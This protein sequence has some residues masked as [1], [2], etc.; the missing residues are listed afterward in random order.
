MEELCIHT[1]IHSRYQVFD[2][3]GQHPFSIVFGLCRR[4]PNDIDTRPIILHTANSFLDV[5]YAIAHGLLTLH[6]HHGEDGQEVRVDLVGRLRLSESEFGTYLTV[7]SPVDRAVHWREAMAIYQYPIEPDSE[8]ASVLRPGRKYTIRLAGKDLGVKWWA[9]GDNDQLPSNEAFTTR[10]LE[11]AKLV[12]SKPSAGKASFAVLPAL[13][14]PPKVETHMRLCRS[15]ETVD[16][17][18]GVGAL[19][20]SVLNTGDQSVTIQTRGQQRFL[21]PWGPFQPEE[22][23]AS[24][25]RIIDATSP[26]PNSGLLV[27]DAATGDVVRHAMKPGPCDGLTDSNVDHR[28]KLGSL[29]T[30]IAGEP[31][32]RRV[33]ISGLLNGILDGKYRIQMLPRG[34]WWCVGSYTEIRNEGDGDDRVPRRL[35]QTKIPPL[36]LET[37]DTVEVRIENGRIKN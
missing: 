4:Q 25:P 10:A 18:D 21:M 3:S 2:A 29:V 19:A 24:Q 16:D 22:I 31:L 26:A 11:T 20:I 34:V 12:N 35:Y 36:M 15:E 33:D 32:V 23:E 8:L 37:E 5:P 9:Y 1:A 30:L 17:S 27:V 14:R 13:P 7:P 28:P 6:E